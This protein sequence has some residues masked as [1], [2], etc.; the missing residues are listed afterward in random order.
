MKATLRRLPVPRRRLRLQGS[1]LL[2]S[3][4]QEL[5]EDEAEYLGVISDFSVLC[6]AAIPWAAFPWVKDPVGGGDPVG[7]GDPMGVCA[8]TGG[9]DPVG[10]GCTCAVAIASA[11]AFS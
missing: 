3:R 5:L 4:F 8:P 10:C 2:G 1:V 7:S 11:A 6:A 9:C